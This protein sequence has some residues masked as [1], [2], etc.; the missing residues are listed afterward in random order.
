MIISQKCKI[1]VK[2][3][4]SVSNVTKS[5]NVTNF[6]R[7]KIVIF[8]HQGRWILMDIFRNGWLMD[9]EAPWQ[10]HLKAI[11]GVVAWKEG[12]FYWIK[13]LLKELTNDPIWAA[14]WEIDINWKIASVSRRGPLSQ[15]YFDFV[16]WHCMW[17]AQQRLKCFVFPTGPAQFHNKKEKQHLR[18]SYISEHLVL[19]G[20]PVFFSLLNRGEWAI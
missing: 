9:I 11:H 15:H 17:N 14:L 13:I 1:Y 6:Q 5:E 4:Y 16:V 18:K 20:W 12:V 3:C 7:W 8:G 19:V 2:L 10:L